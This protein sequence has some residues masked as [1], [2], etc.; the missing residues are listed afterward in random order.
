[1]SHTRYHATPSR[2]APQQA[3]QHDATQHNPGRTLSASSREACS[4][5]RFSEFLPFPFK[6]FNALRTLP[7]SKRTLSAGFRGNG[8]RRVSSVTNFAPGMSKNDDPPFRNLLLRVLADHTR[9]CFT[10][11]EPLFAW[12]FPCD[13]LS[14]LPIIVVILTPLRPFFLRFLRRDDRLAASNVVRAALFH[15]LT[16][17]TGWASQSMSS[18][19][20]VVS[21]LWRRCVDDS[22]GSPSIALF[23]R[24][25]FAVDGRGAVDSTLK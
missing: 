7:T 10:T 4:A 20:E 9:V 12:R 25:D 22:R 14:F 11:F 5:D 19:P 17:S 23:V 1:M 24:L 2:T 8:L 21:L 18:L 6:R 16:C 13:Q 15:G 3:R